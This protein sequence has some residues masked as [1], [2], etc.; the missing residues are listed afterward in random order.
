M[1]KE[2]PSW[3]I[4]GDWEMKVGLHLSM[5]FLDES[6]V[7]SSLLASYEWAALGSC[8]ACLWPYRVHVKHLGSFN[9][10]LLAMGEWLTFRRGITE[11][12]CPDSL[13]QVIS[14]AVTLGREMTLYRNACLNSAVF[15]SWKTLWVW[16]KKKCG[17]GETCSFASHCNVLCWAFWGEFF[18]F[19]YSSLNKIFFVQ[20]IYSP[21]RA[22]EFWLPGHQNALLDV[23]KSLA[24][25]AQTGVL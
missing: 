18:L 24:G 23:L 14:T 21:W 8:Q 25:E 5:I 17:W 1:S 9:I 3:W 22:G 15:F 10:K 16:K 7:T 20:L 6:S 11:N 2:Q 13:T 19:S 4:S 12:Q